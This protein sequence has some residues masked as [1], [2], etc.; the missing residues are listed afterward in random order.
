[1][2]NVQSFYWMDGVLNYAV[3]GDIPRDALRRIALDA[4]DQLT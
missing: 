4:Y 3:V 1:M 2:T